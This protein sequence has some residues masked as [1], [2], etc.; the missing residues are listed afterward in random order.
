MLDLN[1]TFQELAIYSERLK[2]I[3]YLI[4]DKSKKSAQESDPKKAK[5]VEVPASD[6]DEED[7]FYDE[8]SGEEGNRPIETSASTAFPSLASTS[9]AVTSP[10]STS[11]AVALAEPSEEKIVPLAFPMPNVYADDFSVTVTRQ[12]VGPLL[13][14]RKE[15]FIPGRTE[16]FSESRHISLPDALSSFNVLNKSTDAV[17]V[18][19]VPFHTVKPYL[20]DRLKFDPGL[21]SF[22]YVLNRNEFLNFGAYTKRIDPNILEHE[23]GPIGIGKSM[24][25]YAYGNICYLNFLFILV[26][27]RLF[28]IFEY[29]GM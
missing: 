19:E 21:N 26:Y 16:H 24:L 13:N 20:T 27:S 15:V 14:P 3:P 28:Q 25:C 2:L 8:I 23:R 6:D 11:A 5:L 29:T 10:A 9:T 17:V 22:L 4:K 12:Q 7:D 18:V 1:K